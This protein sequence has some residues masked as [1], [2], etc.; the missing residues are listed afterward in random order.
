M[1]IEKIA[2]KLKENSKPATA[3][4]EK[5]RKREKESEIDLK[6]IKQLKM[7]SEKKQN[8][9]KLVALNKK[10]E[11]IEKELEKVRT[12]VMQDGWQTQKHSK[13]S[14]KWDYLAQE[15]MDI[16]MKINDLESEIKNEKLFKMTLNQ[17]RLE[18]H[19]GNITFKELDK[20]FFKKASK[21]EKK[22]FWNSPVFDRSGVVIGKNQTELDD[23]FNEIISW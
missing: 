23:D 8:Q 10:F 15:K 11:A 4:L 14:R 6:Q 19:K 17:A 3:W 5:A 16:L 21:K 1:S 18:Y 7:E 20:V 9:D 2:Q 13:K 22:R 12:S